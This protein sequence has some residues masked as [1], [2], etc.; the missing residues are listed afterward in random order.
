MTA[1]SLKKAKDILVEDWEYYY[2]G[3]IFEAEY[4]NCKETL[5]AL[6]EFEIKGKCKEIKNENYVLNRDFLKKQN[7]KQGKNIFGNILHDG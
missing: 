4:F 2:R 3:R 6:K 7:K 1:N 5:N